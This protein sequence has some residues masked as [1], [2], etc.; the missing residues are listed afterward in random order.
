VTLSF[1]FPDAAVNRYDR[2]LAALRQQLPGIT[3]S[4]RPDAHQGKLSEAAR[5]LI[6]D[7]WALDAAP[8]IR[9]Q[10]HMVELR[11]R[12]SGPLD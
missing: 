6:P 1:H 9:I 10:H 2:H 11:L 5:V 7:G 8:L 3:I 12:G 4:V